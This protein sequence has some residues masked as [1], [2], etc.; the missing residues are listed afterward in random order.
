MATK[1]IPRIDHI[2]LD[3]N[4]ARSP[5]AKRIL[6][7]HQGVPLT[8]ITDKETFLRNLEKMPLTT[9]KRNLWLTRFKGDFLKPCP[10]TG[11]EY[12]CCRY[13]VLNA[14]NPKTPPYS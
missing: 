11:A 14:Q 1:Q 8:T 9:G 4:A 3:K 12:L 6:R 2:Y 5:L 10:A 7:T 13:W